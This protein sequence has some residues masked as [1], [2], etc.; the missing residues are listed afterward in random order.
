MKNK[1]DVVLFF[2]GEIRKKSRAR[3]TSVKNIVIS[4]LLWQAWSFRRSL[5]YTQLRFVSVEMT[6]KD[7]SS[8]NSQTLKVNKLQKIFKNFIEKNISRHNILWE[9]LPTRHLDRNEWN[10]WSGEISYF[11]FSKSK[12]IVDTFRNFLFLS[13]ILLLAS[14]Q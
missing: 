4:K 6:Y 8:I 9:T 10:E 5:H 14:K 13:E 12:C 2:C 1:T 7:K 3:F 11:C